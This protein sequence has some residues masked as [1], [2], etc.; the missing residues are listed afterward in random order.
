MLGFIFTID[1]EVYGNGDGDLNTL[2]IQPTQ[3][4]ID[5]ANEFNAKITIFAEVAEI[6]AMKRD[7]SYKANIEKVEKQLRDAVRQGHDVQLHLHPQWFNA[8]YKF[9]KW[10]LNLENISIAR[11]PFS[12]SVEILNTGKKYLENL[13]ADVKPDY[14]CCA[15]RSGY[16][17]MVP[18]RN[19]ISALRA[20][21]MES[22]SSVFKWGKEEG[23]YIYYDYLTA[24]SN[25]MPWFPQ[26]NNINDAG[27]TS[28]GLIEIP[29][30]TEKVLIPSMITKKR[31]LLRNLSKETRND[32]NSRDTGRIR[33]IIK[34]LFRQHPKKFDFC[35][36]TFSEM[37]KMVDNIVKYNQENIIIPICAIGHSKDFIYTDDYRKI[38]KYITDNY[39]KIIKI[40][41]YR[42]VFDASKDWIF[43]KKYTIINNKK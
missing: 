42:N 1:Y 22:D 32:L 9:G 41:N 38:L 25:Y 28:G 19:I 7:D 37:K 20:V 17:C 34:M 8:E 10:M 15:F 16:W 12:K 36:L 39:G 4:F 33:N 30:Y 21:G 3:K 11:F 18:S 13:F 31:L 5:I 23:D 40:D 43:S 2:A 14:R 24:Y 27:P 35:K 6:I 29:I 26:T